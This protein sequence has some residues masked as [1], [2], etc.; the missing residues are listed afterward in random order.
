M[1]ILLHAEYHGD[2]VMVALAALLALRGHGPRHQ[3]VDAT[4]RVQRQARLDY[5]HKDGTDTQVCSVLLS[6]A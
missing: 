3:L 6:L 5:I 2:G 1:I 4:L